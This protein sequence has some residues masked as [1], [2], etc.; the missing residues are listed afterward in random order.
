[1]AMTD[2]SPRAAIVTLGCPMNQVDSEHIMG[3]LVSQGFEIVSEEDAEVIIVNTCGFIG[4]ARE[5]SIDSILSIAELKQTGSLKALVVAG[6]LAER[7]RTELENELTE[8]DAVAVLSDRDRIPELCLN[9]L[10][11]KKQTESF[12]SRVVSGPP[13]SACLKISEGCDNRCT[14]CTI[15]AIRGPYRSVPHDLILRDAEELVSTGARELILIG[16][17]TTRYG[18]DLNGETL[19][20][21]L[22]KLSEIKEVKWL[23]LMYTH[24]AK[25]TDELIDVLGGNP[26]VLPY[27]D[28][29]VQHIS[30]R[31]LR[32]MCRHTTPH[33]IRSL[34][35]TIRE[36]I[37]GVVLRTAL[38]TGFPGETDKDFDELA[39]FVRD[40]R[41]ERLGA[42]VYSSEEGTPAAK[43]ANHVP[44]E[45]AAERHEII[46]EIQ[47]GIS[48]DF[49][50][51]LI[52]SEFDVIVDEVDPET[53]SAVGRTYMDAP[54]VDCTVSVPQGVKDDSA[55]CRVRITGT[56]AYD[57]LGE[58]V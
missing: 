8:A 4:D 26:K 39:D 14:F 18:S 54:D 10:G 17:D 52:G 15:P 16:Q 19:P 6:C 47:S 34:I 57:L 13:N 23:R 44:V 48:E 42:F 45:T 32:R 1:M 46:M 3:G 51:S 7:Y 29:P 53:G 27:I 11:R 31:V 41:F 28:M 50:S 37:D 33:A 58:V 38:I 5:E 24:P 9:L 20:G 25:F 12:Y 40:I 30:D 35:D 43:M 2:T 55:F 49:H 21:L 56:G 36:R 22:M